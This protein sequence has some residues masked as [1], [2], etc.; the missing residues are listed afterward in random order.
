MHTGRMDWYPAAMSLRE[1]ISR[2]RKRETLALLLLAGG[3]FLMLSVVSYDFG[4]IPLLRYP[5]HAHPHNLMGTVGAWCAF[6]LLMLFGI[7][8]YL[9]PVAVFGTGL[10]LIFGH[11]RGQ[12]HLP[13]WE[14]L[15]V[16]ALACL[17]ELQPELWAPVQEKVNLPSPGGL[18]G[19]LLGRSVLIRYFG[20]LGAGATAATVA[21][22]AVVYLFDFAPSSIVHLILRAASTAG[23]LLLAAGRSLRPRASR[24]ATSAGTTPRAVGSRP[25]RVRSPI[26]Q[27]AIA[28][29]KPPPTPPPS[30]DR[31]P[32][33]RSPKPPPA[34]KR[35]TAAGRRA[36]LPSTGEYRLP[37]LE[38]LDV[39]PPDAKRVFRDNLQENAR[40]LQETLAEFGIECRVTNVERGPVVT[41]YEVLPS[42][43]VRIERIAGLANNIALTM[44]TTNVRIQAPVPGKG[45]VGIEVP[46]PRTTEVYLREILESEAWRSSRAAL[47]L[48][49]GKDVAGREII[50][51]LAAM[52]HLLIAGAT[53]S[54]KTVCINSLIA[55]LLMTRTPDQLRLMLIDP[56]IVEFSVY[57]DL[58]HLVVPVV[59]DAKKVG[60]CL[61]W[62]INE[63]E[64][65]YR[66]FARAG[67]RNIQ[68]F[69]SRPRLKQ[70]KLFNGEAEE[71]STRADLP[72]HLPYIVIVI[73]ELADLMLV[74]QAEIESC[75]ARL[76]QLSRAVGIHM[77]IATQRPS[78]NVI[79]GTIKANL[80]ARVAFQ[81][82]QKVDSRTILDANGADKLLG[83]GD[84]LFLPPGSSKLVRAQGTLSKDDEIARIV[85]FYKQQGKPRYETAITEKMQKAPVDQE[86]EEDEE[87]IEKA[88]EIILQTRRAS[89]S[90]LQRRL[91]IGYTRAA[92]VMD[93]LE[94]RGIVGPPRGAEPREILI[95]DAEG[96]RRSAQQGEMTGG[97]S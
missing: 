82:A 46:N 48:A 59:T 31:K 25:P 61:R 19:A 47:P 38:L 36:P 26:R 3:V 58:P 33:G 87:L 53:G 60:F 51:D 24:K 70:G 9:A 68:S 13:A 20:P 45:V 66:L 55:G 30:S 27:A 41:R 92:R 65:R 50:A 57:N 67:V 34:R 7:A 37:P 79:T 86:A 10:L 43:G 77:I 75:V 49:V 28:A 11:R 78:V 4:D 97:E 15:L 22:V 12:W 85:E 84:M 23:R 2:S 72:E 32:G 8:G 88:V 54:G 76:A 21:L 94:Q 16:V 62:A 5:P 96:P 73:D 18:T 44:K 29:V 40:V 90:A 64:V 69:N 14:M 89:T 1:E 52:P 56:K 91:R 80:P 17:V 6:L 83:R 81:V 95:A 35:G 63:M 71:S 39:P 74:A 93:I 42:P